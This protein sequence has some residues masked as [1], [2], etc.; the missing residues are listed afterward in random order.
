MKGFEYF[1]SMKSTWIQ[2]LWKKKNQQQQ[3][4]TELQKQSC[5]NDMLDGTELHTTGGN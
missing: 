1:V 2:R 3:Q 4:K 5:R